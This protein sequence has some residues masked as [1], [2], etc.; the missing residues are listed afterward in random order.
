MFP[1]A[2]LRELVSHHIA[3]PPGLILGGLAQGGHH[4]RLQVLLG[5]QRGDAHTGFHGQQAH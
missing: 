2:D 3:D 5:Q 1:H 4:Q